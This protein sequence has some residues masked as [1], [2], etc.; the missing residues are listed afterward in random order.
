MAKRSWRRFGAIA[1]LA[2]AL[3]GCAGIPTEG[4]VTEGREAARGIQPAPVRVL[5][6]PPRPR[7][8]ATELIRGFLTA[9]DA[10]FYDDATARSFL[11]PE[12]A[13][14]WR[15][16]RRVVIDDPG[17]P[18]V[19]WDRSARRVSVAL[20]QRAMIT[21]DG[22]YVRLEAA[23]RITA[24]F[25]VRRVSGE[26]RIDELADRAL[27]T[28]GGVARTFRAANLYFLSPDRRVVVPDQ[29]LLP[30]G[31]GLATAA[32]DHL[33]RGPRAA[34]RPAAVTA[35]PPGAARNLPVVVQDG[36]ATVDLD[37]SVLAAS[38]E[39]HRDMAAQL[40]WTLGQIE[41]VRAVRL[42][43]GGD[44]LP[45][46]AGQPRAVDSWEAYDPR[47]SGAAA[48]FVRSGRL[49]RVDGGRFAPVEGPLGDGSTSIANPAVSVD[50]S[51]A[52]GTSVD[53][54]IV[55]TAG[56]SPPGKV[57]HVLGQAGESP[58]AAPSW[59]RLGTLWVVQ[60]ATGRLFALRHGRSVAA[61]D[62]DGLRGRRLVALA[63]SPDGTRLAGIA[64]GERGREVVAGTI[65]RSAGGANARVQEF[66]TVPTGLRNVQ[67]VAWSELDR[68]LVLGGSGAVPPAAVEVDVDGYVPVPRL[69]LRGATSVAATPGLPPVLATSD[70]LI[71]VADGLRWR[72]LG[73]GGSPVYPG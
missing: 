29:V 4:P 41:E 49:G 8:T 16:E 5:A 42:T 54:D 13:A 40:G 47:G 62:V 45:E 20:V 70:G 52:A 36:I 53:G 27:L 1:L 17:R 61:V 12:A 19:S 58:Y 46:G 55:L 39:S 51:S 73:E 11:T 3:A 6:D 67:D 68:L 34:L 72:R 35:F 21:E 38:P 30:D 50:G 28:S 14:S 43:V 32:V 60:P 22:R 10:Y 59:D 57:T 37:E 44:P 24:E 63:V 23:R 31:P 33:L 48:Y 18:R 71:W 56:I 9:S 25:G 7:M 15:P 69:S 65:A 64:A 2:G 26:W 66:R